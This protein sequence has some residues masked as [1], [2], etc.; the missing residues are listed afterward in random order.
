MSVFGLG[1]GRL[2]LGINYNA[3]NM[4]NAA[5]H[6][7]YVWWVDGG[8]SWSMCIHCMTSLLL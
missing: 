8:W 2:G 4:G 1:L 7:R 5:W 6:I 3:E